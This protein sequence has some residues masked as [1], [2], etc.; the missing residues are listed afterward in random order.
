MVRSS[1]VSRKAQLKIAGWAGHGSNDGGG[2]KIGIP[3]SISAR[4]R[5]IRDY[6]PLTGPYG[7]L[8]CIQYDIAAGCVGKC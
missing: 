3:Q 7:S 5:G 8:R 2:T 1:R 6:I 4:G